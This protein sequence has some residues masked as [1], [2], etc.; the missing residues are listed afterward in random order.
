MEEKPAAFW[1]AALASTNRHESVSPRFIFSGEKGISKKGVYGLDAE[2][3]EGSETSESEEDFEDFNGND[4]N[5]IG[6]DE[7]RKQEAE[8]AADEKAEE[9]PRSR[10]EAPARL[11]RNLQIRRLRRDRGTMPRIC[12]SGHGAPFVSRH[13]QQKIRIMKGP[14][15][16]AA[17]AIRRFV[18]ITA[19]LARTKV[20]KQTSKPA[21]WLATSGPRPCLL[22]WLKQKVTE[23][24]SP[25]RACGNL[26]PAPATN[27]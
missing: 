11:T 21:W 4:G 8:G 5:D 26:S 7:E 12:L 14:L 23:M 13:V 17:K 18:Q 22:W 3:A 19:R 15:R 1:S 10:E 2:G 27:A 24:R 20:T 6:N 9:E 25:Q 16:N